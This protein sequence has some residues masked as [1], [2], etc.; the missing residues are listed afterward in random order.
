MKHMTGGYISRVF[1]SK[2]VY[3]VLPNVDIFSIN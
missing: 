1:Q 3:A 2:Y